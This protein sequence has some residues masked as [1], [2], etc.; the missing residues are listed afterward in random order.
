MIITEYSRLELY[1][2]SNINFRYK[3]TNL[4]PTIN[5]LT[6]YKGLAY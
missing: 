4:I 6:I 3:L 5:S 1:H 2:L